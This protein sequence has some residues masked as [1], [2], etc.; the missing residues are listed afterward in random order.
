VFGPEGLQSYLEGFLASMKDDIELRIEDEG[1]PDLSALVTIKVLDAGTVL[2]ENGLSVTAMR[3]IHPPLIDTFALSF[4]DEN[5]GKHVVFSG[6]TAYHPPLAAFAK[7][8]DLLIHEA[9][10]AE[11]LP[12]LMERVG[13]G[14]K[15]MQHWLRS[16]TYANDA[17]RI[18]K[19][20]EVK[21]L[22]LHHLIP[23]DDPSFTVEHW[24][25]AVAE[26]WEGSFHLGEDGL[27]IDLD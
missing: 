20:A 22:A 8:A 3:S 18:A 24:Q 14:D 27:R 2:E 21:A 9:M 1:R 10:L 23:S 19:D 26:N 16:H 7:R 12:A 4:R 5:A 15:L 6:D 13:G 25:I 11:A 17:A